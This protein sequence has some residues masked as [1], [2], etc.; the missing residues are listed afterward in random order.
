[1]YYVDTLEYLRRGRRSG[2]AAEIISSL[3][4]L[5]PILT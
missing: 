4:Q 5:K 3:L 1:M 2:R